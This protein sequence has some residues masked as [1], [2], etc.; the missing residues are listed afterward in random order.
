MQVKGT[1]IKM[2]DT[3]TVNLVWECEYIN[4]TGQKERSSSKE[5]MDKQP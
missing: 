3:R 2:N 5:K 1:V 4:Y